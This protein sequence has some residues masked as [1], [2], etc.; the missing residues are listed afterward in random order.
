MNL[1]VDPED[2]PVAKKMCADVRSNASSEIN[3]VT[4]RAMDAAMK[5]VA[6]TPPTTFASL[7]SVSG[8][9]PESENRVISKG[10]VV[11]AQPSAKTMKFA[12][13]I[14]QNL[15]K[16]SAPRATSS[17]LMFGG[18]DLK[19]CPSMPLSHDAL[20]LESFG[21]KG[22]KRSADEAFAPKSFGDREA[23]AP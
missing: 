16:E 18:A 2:A 21:R 1:P 23:A 7:S 10:V 9:R 3:A 12:S 20:A 5:P 6:V 19:S 17:P 4:P 13:S 11:R 22:H 14:F 15:Q 8:P